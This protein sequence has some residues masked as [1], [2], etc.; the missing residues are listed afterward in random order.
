MNSHDSSKCQETKRAR[1]SGERVS[2]RSF[3]RVAWFVL[4]LIC[5]ACSRHDDTPWA[6]GAKAEDF[7]DREWVGTYTGDALDGYVSVDI[8]SFG[9]VIYRVDVYGKQS[10]WLGRVEGRTV[11]IAPS[12]ATECRP[13]SKLVMLSLGATHCLVDE[14]AMA[15]A[16]KLIN[17]HEDPGNYVLLRRGGD[18]PPELEG[19]IDIPPPWNELLR[20]ELVTANILAIDDWVETR[21]KSGEI[22]FEQRA[23]FDIG[24]KQGV[25]IGMP[26]YTLDDPKRIRYDVESFDDSTCVGVRRE[27][28]KPELS[29]TVGAKCATRDPRR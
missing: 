17:R 25:F 11:V 21:S 19:M 18:P 20:V 29:P 16:C 12:S 13:E 27:H 1:R 22:E 28:E 4:L 24:A 9:S 23:H 5:A 6:D 8:P 26:L 7:N 14:R 3:N 10:T 15:W 2:S